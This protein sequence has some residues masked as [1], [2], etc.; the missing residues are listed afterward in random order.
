VKPE[1]KSWLWQSE[2]RDLSIIGER[3][4]IGEMYEKNVVPLGVIVSVV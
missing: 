2:H 3:L 1:V 4:L